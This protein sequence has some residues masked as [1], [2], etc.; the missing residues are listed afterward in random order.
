MA[1][2]AHHVVV[3]R[4]DRPRGCD[5]EAGPKGISTNEKENE[6]EGEGERESESRA[7][8]GETDGEGQKRVV[9]PRVVN[10]GGRV[11]NNTEGQQ[12]TPRSDALFKSENPPRR[13]FKCPRFVI[14][15]NTVRCRRY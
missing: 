15:L 3:L 4:W 5:G 8:A 10:G 2:N 12:G 13:A 6:H 9:S 14:P 7:R 11:H 1:R